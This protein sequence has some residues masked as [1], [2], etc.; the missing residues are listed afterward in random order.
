MCSYAFTHFSRNRLSNPFWTHTHTYART[1]KKFSSRFS[2]MPLIYDVHLIYRVN[3]H[4]ARIINVSIQV[5][6]SICVS[7]KKKLFFSQLTNE[8]KT[9]SSL[10]RFLCLCLFRC[11][12]LPLCK[13]CS[14]IN[15]KC[16]F[17]RSI[18]I[19]L[20]IL[21]VTR[22]LSPH[23]QVLCSLKMCPN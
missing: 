20:L 1:K 21:R 18:G 5:F 10:F 19:Y 16:I 11:L 8:E 22:F 3:I 17:F 23:V 6:S 15:D 9:Y 2:G 4:D 12:S 7:M 13:I 14:Q